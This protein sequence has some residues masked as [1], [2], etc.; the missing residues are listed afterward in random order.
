MHTSKFTK[1]IKGLGH[2]DASERRAAVE[3]LSEGD[4]RAV[5]PL[6]KALRDE[7][8]GVQDAAMRSLIAIGGEVT[9]YMVLPLLRENPFLRNT[10]LIILKE[11]GKATTPLL[12]P[13]LSD[14]D[15]DVRKFALDL[16]YDIRD[17][18][19]PEKIAEILEQDSNANVRAA[20]A[21][22]IGVLQYKEA[23]AQLMNALKDEEWVCFSAL[24]ALAD[25]S[26]EMSVDSISALLNSPSD[27]IRYAAIE[28]IGKIGSSGASNVLIAHMAR[29]DGLEKTAA[30]KSLIQIGITPSMTGISDVLVDMLK[31]GD[32]EEK[33]IALKGLVDIREKSAIYHMVDIA[34]SLD[35]SDPDNDEKLLIIKDAIQTFG[36]EDSFIDILDDPSI[37]YRGRA[38]A[39]EVLGD[40]KCKNAVPGLIRLLNTEFRDVRRASIRSLGEISDENAKQSLIDAIDD[41]DSHVRR[42]AVAALGKIGEMAAFESLMK[43][44]YTERYNDITEETVSALLNIN[45]S[46]FFSHIDEFN[47][48]IRKIAARFA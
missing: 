10:A 7:N 15:D 46:L 40:L 4:E 33:N 1:S 44:L 19:Y 24:E 35:P 22:A 38:I 25:I 2:P 13:L 21:K 37:K 41:D 14:R 32:W 23:A 28:A 45:P 3:A 12:C 47:D 9:A 30:I 5:Y 31:N 43:L 29:I 39:I 18:D 26:D 20:A 36:C 16:I 34:G 17:C 11:I 6:I 8:F 48:D 27:T 42:T